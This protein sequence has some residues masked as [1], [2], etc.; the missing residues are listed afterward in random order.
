MEHISQECAY[1]FSATC[2]CYFQAFQDILGQNII[3]QLQFR[4]KLYN[5]TIYI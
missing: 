2:F 1:I 5:C 3:K 4:T